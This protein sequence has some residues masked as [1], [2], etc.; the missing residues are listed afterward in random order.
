MSTKK[1]TLTL[2][3]LITFCIQISSVSLQ[4]SLE[5]MAH[6]GS[7]FFIFLVH[8]SVAN[9][10]DPRFLFNIVQFRNDGCSTT[11]QGFGSGIGAGSS[12][13]GTTSL[14]INDEA[15]VYGT[16]YTSQ[17]CKDKGGKEVASCAS[18]FGSCCVCEY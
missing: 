9:D 12:G 2:V 14:N 11:N 8:R 18:G 13:L 15:E 17:Q 4:I 5:E 1:G 16:C 6:F 7:L 10:R 3:F